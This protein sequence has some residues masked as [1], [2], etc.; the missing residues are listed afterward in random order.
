MTK[1]HPSVMVRGDFVEV[2]E[3]DLILKSLQDLDR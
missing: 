3:F 1:L 2:I